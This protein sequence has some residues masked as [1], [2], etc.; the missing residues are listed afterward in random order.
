M[1]ILQTHFKKDHVHVR[2]WTRF[3]SILQAFKVGHFGDVRPL[4]ELITFISDVDNFL[5]GYCCS[6]CTCIHF[7]Q[8]I[9]TFFFRKKNVTTSL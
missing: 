9:V 2:L 1:N 4:R 6:A 7:H 3:Y 5:A 8:E